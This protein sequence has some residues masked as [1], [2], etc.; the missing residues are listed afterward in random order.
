MTRTLNATAGRTP[1][2]DRRLRAA[3]A[4][5]ADHAPRVVPAR[6][7]V[8]TLLVESCGWP[9]DAAVPPRRRAPRR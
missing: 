9:T 8:R 2:N 7:P 1:S 5:A 3:A 4:P 6:P